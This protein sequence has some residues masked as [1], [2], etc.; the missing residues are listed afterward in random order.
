MNT[1]VHYQR[2]NCN[3]AFGIVVFLLAA[4]S[5]TAIM[6]AN[7]QVSRVYAGPN[8]PISGPEPKPTKPVSPPNISPKPTKIT[9]TPKPIKPPRK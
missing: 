8:K 6:A 5:V 3:L 4:F 7:Q 1:I 2:K 9:P